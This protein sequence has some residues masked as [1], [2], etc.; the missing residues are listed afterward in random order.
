MHPS[1]LL[2]IVVIAGAAVV[3][4]HRVTKTP[5]AAQYWLHALPGTTMPDAIADLVKNGSIVLIHNW[6]ASSVDTN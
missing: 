5:A 3:H 1:T 6:S 2:L 4:G